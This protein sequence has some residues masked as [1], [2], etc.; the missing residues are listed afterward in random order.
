MQKNSHEENGERDPD[1]HRGPQGPHA[2]FLGQNANGCSWGNS[3]G[4]DGNHGDGSQSRVWMAW[5][6]LK[7]RQSEVINLTIPVKRIDNC[8]HGPITI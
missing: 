3:G 1:G 6:P 8:D 7:K 4:L 5:R 2:V